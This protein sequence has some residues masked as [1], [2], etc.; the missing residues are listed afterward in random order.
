M[1]KNGQLTPGQEGRSLR[2]H[3]TSHFGTKALSSLNPYG[4]QN[5]YSYLTLQ[6][7]PYLY[8]IDH[9]ISYCEVTVSLNYQVMNLK[10]VKREL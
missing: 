5:Y 9:R 7:M 4:W 6:L 10:V 1:N 8:T 2:A 3:C